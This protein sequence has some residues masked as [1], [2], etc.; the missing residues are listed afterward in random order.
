MEE[1]AR[2]AE[3][4]IYCED[5]FIVKHRLKKSYRHPEIDEKLR[6]FRTN[7]EKK[8]LKK[9]EE[10]NFNAPR[11]EKELHHHKLDKNHFSMTFIKG[12]ALVK[13]LDSVE[14]VKYCKIIGE[15]IAALHENAIIH[16]DLT[17]SNMIANENHEIYFI[18]FGLS[19]FSHKVEDMAVDLHLLKQALE[20]KHYK[21]AD[22]AF[23][24]VIVGYKKFSK[25]DEVMQRFKVVEERGRN[26]KK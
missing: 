3:A 4:V 1:I 12:H 16:A 22:K 25:F 20:S 13:V 7:R 8:I 24:A 5:N 11:V 26:K 18:D 19:Y 17:T 23:K 14:Y 2:G 21:I 10:I 6:K 15:M 9:L